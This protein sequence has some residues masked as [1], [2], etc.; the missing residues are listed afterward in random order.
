LVPDDPV[1]YFTA[2]KSL[3]SVGTIRC[4]MCPWKWEVVEQ[5][6]NLDAIVEA[7]I[8][9]SHRF[10]A[11]GPVYHEPW[12]RSQP[13]KDGFDNPDIAFCVNYPLSSG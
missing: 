9:E 12:D 2:S 5:S 4:D 11:A 10:L 8:A 6:P 13:L 7:H 3:G 1:A